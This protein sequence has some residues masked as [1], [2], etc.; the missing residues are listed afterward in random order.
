MLVGRFIQTA[1]SNMVS[2]K[3]L[4]MVP[5][6]PVW[7][8]GY[9]GF[10]DRS[11]AIVTK[12]TK[13]PP[14]GPIMESRDVSIANIVFSFEPFYRVVL[15]FSGWND[16]RVIA[17]KIRMSIPMLRFADCINI[18]H[19]ARLRGR[20]IIVTVKKDE[21]LQYSKDLE[22]RGLKVFLDEA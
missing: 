8:V 19:Q 22:T 21:A 1:S 4:A 11:I 6:V 14:R 5:C 12:A 15:L 9:G 10:G 2:R 17:R 13:S 18:A 16:D 3:R 20:A 7:G